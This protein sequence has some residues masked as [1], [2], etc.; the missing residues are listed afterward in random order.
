[1]STQPQNSN[2]IRKICQRCFDLVHSNDPG[3]IVW[4]KSSLEPEQGICEC[5]RTEGLVRSATAPIIVATGGCFD[6]L[7]RGHIDLLRQARQMGQ[8]LIILLNSDRSVRELKGAGRPRNTFEDRRAVLLELRS[9]DLVI[10]FDEVE[11]S[12]PLGILRPDI[13]VKDQEYQPSV[14]G[15]GGLPC[16][17]RTV[18]ESYGGRMK[19]VEKK[20]N[21]STTKILGVGFDSGCA[22]MMAGGGSATLE[23]TSVEELHDK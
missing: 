8:F 20:F 2:R 18:I 16:P 4:D 9:V 22:N 6:V 12:I 21:V 11:P 5:C 15:G 14:D 13:W 19:Y 7:H 17:E 10:E 1:M 23:I 3:I